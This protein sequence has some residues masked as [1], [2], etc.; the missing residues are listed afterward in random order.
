MNRLV[1][2]KIL[3]MKQ[4]MTSEYYFVVCTPHKPKKFYQFQSI[5]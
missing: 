3:F 4:A 2:L 5:V 1:T